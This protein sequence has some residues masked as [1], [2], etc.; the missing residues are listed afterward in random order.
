MCYEKK[1]KEMLYTDVTEWV[2]SPQEA[3]VK[4]YSW[5]KRLER[6]RKVQNSLEHLESSRSFSLLEPKCEELRHSGR[7]E[8]TVQPRVECERTM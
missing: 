5:K 7:D 3:G 4:G 6:G 1:G 8:L 2:V